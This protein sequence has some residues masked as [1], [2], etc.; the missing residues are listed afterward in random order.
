MVET[1]PLHAKAREE[2]P[3]LAERASDSGQHVAHVA[4]EETKR[5]GAEAGTQARS[6]LHEAGGELREQAAAQQVRLAGGLRSWF[7]VPSPAS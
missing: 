2:A 1:E 3:R 6:L 4:R 7:G 5:V